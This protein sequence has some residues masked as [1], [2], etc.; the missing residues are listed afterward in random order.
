MDSYPKPLDLSLP[1]RGTWGALGHPSEIPWSPLHTGVNDAYLWG[2]RG[3]QKNEDKHDLL[4]SRATT[5]TV[6]QWVGHLEAS[7]LAWE[8]AQSP[9]S[10]PAHLPPRA[11]NRAGTGPACPL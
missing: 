11:G 9:G 2:V 3:G 6:T 5:F 8:Q 1:S 10:Q 4:P 7:A